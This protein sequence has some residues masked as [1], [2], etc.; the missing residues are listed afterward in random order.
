[1]FGSGFE[2][3]LAGEKTD[4]GQATDDQE[5]PV[6][7][8]EGSIDDRPDH[9]YG[10]YRTADSEN[11]DAFIDPFAVNVLYDARW[12]VIEPHDCTHD[13][14]Q[15]ARAKSTTVMNWTIKPWNVET[16]RTRSATSDCSVLFGFRE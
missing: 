8:N 12:F 11:I 14:E 6:T 5:Q 10:L 7:L 4:S 13:R 15:A 16:C 1:M 3:V 9:Y 2:R